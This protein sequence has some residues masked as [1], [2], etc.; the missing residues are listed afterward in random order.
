MHDGR[1]SFSGEGGGPT[2]GMMFLNPQ[3]L[4]HGPSRKELETARANWRK[5]ARLEMIA[6]NIDC[7][8]PLELSAPA[9]AALAARKARP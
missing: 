3:G 6:V 7:E 1:F 8:K 4:H 5:D 2:P 9:Q